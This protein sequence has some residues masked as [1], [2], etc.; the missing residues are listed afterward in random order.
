MERDLKASPIQ[1]CPSRSQLR[2]TDICLMT[3]L[4]TIKEVKQQVKGDTMH[5][6]KQKCI[7]MGSDVSSLFTVSLAVY[8]TARVTAETHQNGR[9]HVIPFYCFTRCGKQNHCASHSRKAL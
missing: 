9:G 5:V 7:K 2:F 4:W 8:T 3:L 6:L 1:Q